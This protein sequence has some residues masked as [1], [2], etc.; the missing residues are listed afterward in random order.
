[1]KSEKGNLGSFG[2]GSIVGEEWVFDRELET[3]KENCYAKYNSCV[4]EISA[5]SLDY[6]REIFKEYGHHKYL[7]ILEM[8]MKRNFKLKRRS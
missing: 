2:I 4:L 5:K 7:T 8:Q 1:L 3:R 6:I